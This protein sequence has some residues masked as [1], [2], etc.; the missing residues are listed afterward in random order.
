M[1]PDARRSVAPR[2]SLAAQ[3]EEDAAFFEDWSAGVDRYGVWLFPDIARR[4][5]VVRPGSASED[6]IVRRLGGRR[7]RWHRYD[8]SVQRDWLVPAI[9]WRALKAQVPTL[10][11][12]RHR[13]IRMRAIVERPAYEVFRVRVAGA[14]ALAVYT[15]PDRAF[16]LAARRLGARFINIFER[17]GW[18]IAADHPAAEKFQALVLAT[19]RRHM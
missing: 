19:R 10:L 12:L 16:A 7:Q 8:Q 6:L 3:R 17:A 4:A 9:N 2:G 15:R 14:P 18:W 1:T 5:I 13:Q 11:A